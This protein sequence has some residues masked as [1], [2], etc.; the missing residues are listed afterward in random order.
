MFSAVAKATVQAHGGSIGVRSSGI[1][2]EGSVFTVVLKL[3]AGTG[4]TAD[5]EA[6]VMESIEGTLST[7]EKEEREVSLE[8]SVYDTCLIVDDSPLNRKFLSRLLKPHF[9]KIDT[10]V[11]G[12]EAR[13][14]VETAMARG[15]PP[16]DLICMDSVMPVR[17][18]YAIHFFWT[19]F[20]SVSCNGTDWTYCRIFVAQTLPN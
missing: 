6:P 17:T 13:D 3:C 7:L 4:D 1:A 15:Q 9:R 11:D 8:A 14:I 2:G 16:Y 20:L 12:E 5:N 19:P 18:S 10:A